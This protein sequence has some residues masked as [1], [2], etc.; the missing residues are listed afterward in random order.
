VAFVSVAA[1]LLAIAVAVLSYAAW[2]F[3][4]GRNLLQGEVNDRERVVD[5]LSG[6]VERLLRNMRA[7]QRILEFVQSKL[8]RFLLGVCEI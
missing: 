8:G 5:E 1:G 3:R 2:V 4:V 7:G 6:E